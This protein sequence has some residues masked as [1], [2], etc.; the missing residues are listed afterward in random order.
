[1]QD[2]YQRNASLGDPQAVA[3]QLDEKSE[4]F[5]QIGHELKKY[6]VG[7]NTPFTI[8]LTSGVARNS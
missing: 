3:K 5:N 8:A 1:M 2:V 4:K 6:E 7:S